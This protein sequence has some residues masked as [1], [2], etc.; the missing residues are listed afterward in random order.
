MVNLLIKKLN[1]QCPGTGSKWHAE[2]DGCRQYIFFGQL[3]GPL[4]R[5][6]LVRF[7]KWMTMATLLSV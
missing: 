3:E 2:V 6:T 7:P 4:S 5:F 1:E